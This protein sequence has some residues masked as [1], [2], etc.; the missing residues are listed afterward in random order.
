MRL[1]NM[2]PYNERGKDYFG[3][4]VMAV[5]CG[6]LCYFFVNVFARIVLALGKVAYRYWWA[7]LIVLVLIIFIR[8]RGRKK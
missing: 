2:N 3:Y 5:L 6:F 8:K 1:N 4:G 7:S